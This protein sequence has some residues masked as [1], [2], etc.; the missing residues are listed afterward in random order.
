MVEIRS[1][2]DVNTRLKE[3]G[4]LEINEEKLTG[5]MNKE[6]QKVKQ[7]YEGKIREIQEKKRE[8]EKAIEEFVWKNRPENKTVKLTFGEIQ[9]RQIPEKITFTKDREIVAQLLEKRGFGEAVEIKRRIVMKKLKMIVKRLSSEV[10]K[11]LGIAVT[12][13]A[14]KVNVKAYIEKIREV[15]EA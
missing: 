4:L 10:L 15:P 5:E 12:A 13:A 1:W 8:I 11:E 9:I 6:I 3:Y 14:E 7:K 2:E